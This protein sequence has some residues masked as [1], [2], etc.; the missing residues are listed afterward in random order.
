MVKK[1]L[2]WLSSYLLVN[3]DSASK[4][5]LLRRT[6]GQQR[7]NRIWGTVKNA[8]KKD[9]HTEKW[10]KNESRDRKY[11]RSERVESSSLSFFDGLLCITAQLGPGS[12]QMR[13]YLLLKRAAL[14]TVPSGDSLMYFTG[15]VNKHCYKK[16]P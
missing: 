16:L 11:R 13:G 1:F 4:S 3:K 15:C 2:K 5:L 10:I 14:C 12:V 7:D 8:A 9:W 6:G